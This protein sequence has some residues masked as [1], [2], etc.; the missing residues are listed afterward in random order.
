[1]IV[2]IVTFFIESCTYPETIAESE[3]DLQLTSDSST[4]YKLDKRYFLLIPGDTATFYGSKSCS[5]YTNGELESNSQTPY[6]LRTITYPTYD[7]SINSIRYFVYPQ[8]Y[9]YTSSLA[10]FERGTAATQNLSTRYFIR[11]DS[12]VIQV[13]STTYTTTG[14]TMDSSVHALAEHQQ[15]VIPRLI[16]VGHYGWFQSDSTS[17]PTTNKWYTSPLIEHPFYTYREQ[18]SFEGFSVSPEPI[19]LPGSTDKPYTVSGVEYTNGIFVNS[20]YTLKGS[21]VEKG[22]PVELAGKVTIV[23][24]Y[25]TDRGMIDQSI[26]MVVQKTYAN[27]TQIIKES[28]YVSRGPEGARVYPEKDYP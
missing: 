15:K 2:V 1:M 8:R 14:T 20:Y 13:K 28:S 5:L 18:V 9:H 22:S 3:T 4:I 27:K 25:F 10:D 21:I 17:V 11:H 24:T 12:A 26:D 6:F 7:T 16:E 23:R 19:V